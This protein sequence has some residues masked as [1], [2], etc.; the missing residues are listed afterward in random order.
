[1]IV[2]KM[3][4]LVCKCLSVDSAVELARFMEK[5]FNDVVMDGVK[6]GLKFYACI[7]TDSPNPVVYC[8][9]PVNEMGQK[10]F[11]E[12]VNEFKAMKLAKMSKR[13]PAPF[14]QSASQPGLAHVC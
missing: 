2:F 12:A 13:P 7:G 9:V 8:E 5:K 14:A 11:K 10:E 1:M 4:S 6:R 3:E